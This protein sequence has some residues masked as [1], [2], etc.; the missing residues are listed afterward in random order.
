LNWA[1][2]LDDTHLDRIGP[3]PVLGEISLE[4]MPVSIYGHQL[5]HMRKAQ[6]KLVERIEYER[7]SFLQTLWRAA[8]RR[9]AVLRQVWSRGYCLQYAYCRAGSLR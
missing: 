9:C 6:A 2:T 4:T 3:H 5:F 8:G 1:R 7:K